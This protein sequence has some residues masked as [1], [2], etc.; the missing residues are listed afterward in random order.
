MKNFSW[1]T[2]KLPSPGT[3]HAA[4]CMAKILEILARPEPDRHDWARQV[5]E[6]STSGERVSTAAYDMAK[7]AL[8]EAPSRQ[9][10]ED[11]EEDDA[12]PV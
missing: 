4:E 12:Q 2:P 1:L 6:R 10:G 3:A 5:L 9:P 8:A 11:M 7:K